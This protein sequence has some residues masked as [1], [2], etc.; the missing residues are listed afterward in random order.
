M[1]FHGVFIEWIAELV[2]KEECQIGIFFLVPLFQTRAQERSPE[3][4]R[5]FYTSGVSGV[6][7]KCGTTRGSGHTFISLIVSENGMETLAVGA[8][9]NSV[10]NL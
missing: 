3:T 7:E 10:A 2:G 8:M 4:T 1:R 5:C 6:S 9:Q